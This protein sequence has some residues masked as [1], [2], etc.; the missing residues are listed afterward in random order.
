MTAEPGAG[1]RAADPATPRA[2]RVAP[3]RPTVRTLMSPHVLTVS[4]DETLWDAWQLMFVSGLHHLVVTDPEGAPLGMVS[5]RGLLAEL[6][7]TPEHLEHRRVGELLLRGPLVS[8]HPDTSPEDAARTLAGYGTE[9]APVL[10]DAGRLVGLLTCIDLV[11]WL[12]AS[13]G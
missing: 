12:A 7:L 13:D 1:D 2:R 10:D 3:A 9:A 8:V 5:D 4:T 6:P 11:R